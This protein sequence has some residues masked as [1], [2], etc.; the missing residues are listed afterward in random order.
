MALPLAVDLL[1]L[2]DYTDNRL[3]AGLANRVH[4]SV[5]R[6]REREELYAGAMHRSPP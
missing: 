3:E 5:Q 4:L 6:E 1:C 2:V